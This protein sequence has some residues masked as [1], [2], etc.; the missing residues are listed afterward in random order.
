MGGMESRAEIAAAGRF[1]PRKSL[2]DGAQIGAE[3]VRGYSYSTS[4]M[5]RNIFFLQC[6]IEDVERHTTKAPQR[7]AGRTEEQAPTL[8]GG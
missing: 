2:V 7:H 8:D 1:Q 5:Q 3:V 6:K 4:L